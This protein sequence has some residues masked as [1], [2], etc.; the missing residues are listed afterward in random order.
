MPLRQSPAAGSFCACGGLLAP[1]AGWGGKLRLSGWPTSAVVGVGRGVRGASSARGRG[2]AG[3]GRG[4]IGEQRERD[5]HR[6]A[7]SSAAHPPSDPPRRRP[8]AQTTSCSRGGRG[9]CLSQATQSGSPA[10]RQS[11][12]PA[13]IPPRPRHRPEAEGGAAARSG[14]GFGSARGGPKPASHAPPRPQP[15][16]PLN[17]PSPAQGPTTRCR[18]L[19]RPRGRA[20]IGECG[21]ERESPPQAPQPAAGDRPA[22]MERST[23]PPPA[24]R[25][26]RDRPA[27]RRESKPAAGA[28]ASPQAIAPRQWSAPPSLP[29]AARPRRDRPARSRQSKP[30]AGALASPQAIAQRQESERSRPPRDE[31]T[32][33]GRE[34]P[35]RPRGQS[36]RGA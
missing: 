18:A 14:G 9:K 30:A 25:P 22:A 28:L 4:M 20:E 5:G 3:W 31:P 8:V 36:R 12:S 27:R 26:R 35:A 19:P 6:R 24:A 17:P 21:A 34:R 32:E 10:V 2:W 13:D 11:G 1:A 16:A 15:P 29:P 23:F 7:S 33:A